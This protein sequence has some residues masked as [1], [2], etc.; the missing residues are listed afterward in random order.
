MSQKKV[1]KSLE[2]S[3]KR[4]KNLKIT[5]LEDGYEFCVPVDVGV[6]S[7]VDKKKWSISQSV[8]KLSIIPAPGDNNTSLSDIKAHLNIYTRRKTV[9]LRVS[10]EPFDDEYE[11]CVYSKESKEKIEIKNPSKRK[12]GSILLYRV[13]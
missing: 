12:K 4:I 2:V 6:I 9:P 13:H 1:M 3:G 5:I 8:F 7:R 11:L 10:V